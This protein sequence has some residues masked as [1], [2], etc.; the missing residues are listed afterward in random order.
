MDTDQTS[1]SP[2]L[3]VRLKQLALRIIKVHAALPGSPLSQVLGQRLLESGTS[4]GLEYREST[5]APSGQ[6]AV[7]K[8]HSTIQ[9]LDETAY[10][11]ELL[12]D[13]GTMAPTRLANLMKDVDELIA[14]LM[15]SAQNRA[16]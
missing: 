16:T 1:A 7:A 15:I 4:A 11:M 13:S 12:G 9:K 2:D 8:I 3:Q 14:M 10:W 5:R 6:E